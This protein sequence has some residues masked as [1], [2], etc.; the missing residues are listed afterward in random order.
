MKHTLVG[1][2]G[3]VGGNLAAGHSFDGLYNSRNIAE[4]FGQSNGLVVYSGMPSE[5]FL[6]NADPAADLEQARTAFQNICRMKPER[7]VLISTVDVYQTPVAV[8]E[9]SP[10]GAETAPAY[11][12]N[13]FALETW[14]RQEFPG[15][16]IVRLPGLFGKGLKKNFI[17]DAL[18]LVPSVLTEQKY[19]QLAAESPLV[20][21][22]Y[23]PGKAGFYRLGE[24]SSS[25]SEALYAHFSAAAFNSLQFTDSRS[26][27]QFYNLARLW[28]DLERCLKAELL[29]VNMAV[30]PTE[31]GWLYQKVFGGAIENHLPKPPARYDLRTRFAAELGGKDGYLVC[32]EEVA[33]EIAAFAESWK[34]TNPAR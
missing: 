13:R 27:F 20:G 8:Y 2:T 7:L 28:A 3:F 24:L 9:D 12:K 11:G 10:T 14:V 32:A 19:I 34:N 6:A 29:L 1:Y 23:R 18:T 33:G 30:Q 17:Y 22:S 4:S 26:V 25:Q 21:Q 16:L 5:K 15:A 31:A